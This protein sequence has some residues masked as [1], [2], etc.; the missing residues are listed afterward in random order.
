MGKEELT[1]CGDQ[2][3]PARFPGGS[4][5]PLRPTKPLP[6]LLLCTW[7]HGEP[8]Q[9]TANGLVCRPDQLPYH[10]FQSIAALVFSLCP[11]RDGTFEAGS[12]ARH[13]TL[14]CQHRDNPIEA[15]QGLCPNYPIHQTDPLEPAQFVSVAKPL[16]R[17]AEKHTGWFQLESTSSLHACPPTSVVT[18]AMLKDRA[19]QPAF[20]CEIRSKSMATMNIGSP[21]HPLSV[22]NF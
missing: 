19:R 7:G 3:A 15:L 5:W 9:R 6:R 8:D 14:T 1:V 16:C 2:L 4:P 21:K 18:P 13:G 20:S 12:L 11:S 17:N 10:G 22:L